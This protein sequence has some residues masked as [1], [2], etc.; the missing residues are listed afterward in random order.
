MLF[1][2]YRQGMK[3]EGGY[4]CTSYAM[5]YCIIDGVVACKMNVHHRCHGLVPRTCGQ[6]LTEP[7]GRI[8]LAIT[9]AP[10]D[11][12]SQRVNIQS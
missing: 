3:C 5:L 10:L 1:G 4:V 7:Y 9:C 12:D 2:L 8:Q 11:E 6:D